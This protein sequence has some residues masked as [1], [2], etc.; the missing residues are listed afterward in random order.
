MRQRSRRLAFRD[1]FNL[2]SELG[3]AR[4]QFFLVCFKPFA[5]VLELHGNLL[6]KLSSDA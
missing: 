4:G 3:Q 6:L 1:L 5:E 2:L